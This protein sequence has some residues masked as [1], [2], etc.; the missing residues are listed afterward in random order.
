M[1]VFIC[2][3][4]Y[5]PDIKKPDR[6]TKGIAGMDVPCGIFWHIIIKEAAPMGLKT[7]DWFWE[8]ILSLWSCPAVLL[9][10][11]RPLIHWDRP[12]PKLYPNVDLIYLQK[13]LGLEECTTVGFLQPF[14]QTPSST[15]ESYYAV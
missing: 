12:T 5:T 6:H 10:G 15:L 3:L 13:S 14:P 8:W 2:C 7:G 4:Y 1:G 11:A 9:V